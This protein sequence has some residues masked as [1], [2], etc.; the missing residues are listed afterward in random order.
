MDRKLLDILACPA[1]RQPLAPLDAR[2]L[3]ALNGAILAGGVRRVDGTPQAVS[4][5]QLLAPERLRAK[6]A[7][8]QTSAIAGV[9][10]IMRVATDKS[11]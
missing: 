4:S 3:E 1:S 8:A 10:S 6:S 11:R 7:T 9:K 2:G 5:A